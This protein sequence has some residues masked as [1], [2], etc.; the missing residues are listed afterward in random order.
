[1]LGLIRFLNDEERFEGLR[2]LHWPEGVI[3]PHCHAPHIV[4]QGQDDTPRFRQRC[5]C[6]DCQRKLDDLTSTVFTGYHSL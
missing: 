6:P 4:K 5:R 1:M 2:R 3:C